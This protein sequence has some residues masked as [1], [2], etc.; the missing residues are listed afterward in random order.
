MGTPTGGVRARRERSIVYSRPDRSA[1]RSGIAIAVATR[2]EPPSLRET[3]PRTRRMSAKRGA[4]ALSPRS[5]ANRPSSDDATRQ[6]G[7]GVFNA[8]CSPTAA[9][10][11]ICA[12]S[13]SLAL[14]D[15]MWREPGGSY[16]VSPRP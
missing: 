1:A 6:R 4:P 7:S 10:T 5:S 15:T 12:G 3:K 11:T 16:H 8:R 14:R 9:N 13:V 2:R